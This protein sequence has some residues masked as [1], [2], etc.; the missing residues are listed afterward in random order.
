ML[1][2]SGQ[3][4]RINISPHIRLRRARKNKKSAA[5]HCCLGDFVDVCLQVKPV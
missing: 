2:F 5:D 4:A 3:A 1:S